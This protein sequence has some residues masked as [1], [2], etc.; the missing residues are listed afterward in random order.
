M[1]NTF[2]YAIVVIRQT[3]K[4]GFCFIVN[5]LKVKLN[6]CKRREADPREFKKYQ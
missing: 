5:K 4:D 1:M 3:I 6:N 2:E